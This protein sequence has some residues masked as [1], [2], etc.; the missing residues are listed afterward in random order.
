KVQNRCV[1]ARRT[2]VVWL[3]LRSSCDLHFVWRERPLNGQNEAVDR[4]KD[5]ER[6]GCSMQRPRQNHGHHKIPGCFPVPAGTAA[7]RYVQIIAQP[8]TQTDVPAAPEVL[9]EARQ[10][11]LPEIH[12]EMEPH[13]LRG[14]TCYVDIAAKSSVELTRQ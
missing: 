6:P 2:L 13:Q 5:N 4:A 7:Q 1:V 11:G 3:R 10:V 8:G 14:A 9:E 12:Y